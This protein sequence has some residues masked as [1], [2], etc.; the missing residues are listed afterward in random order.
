MPRL[1]IRYTGGEGWNVSAKTMGRSWQLD[2]MVKLMEYG[3]SP[4]DEGL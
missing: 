1:G 4:E 3:K 2:P